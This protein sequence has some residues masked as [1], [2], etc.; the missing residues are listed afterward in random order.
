MQDTWFW[1]IAW[2]L[3]ILSMAGNGF[4]VF[5]VRRNRRLRTK[6]NAF[7][8][9]LAVADFCVP[10]SAVPSRFFCEMVDRCTGMT[11][12]RGLFGY[13]SATNLC[14]LVLDRYMAVAKPLKY[15]TFM[16]SRRVFQLISLSWAIPVAF[17]AAVS[18]LW[19]GLKTLRDIVVGWFYTVYELLLCSIVVF[20]F[21]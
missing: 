9:S 19:Y 5:T 6:T 3:Y 17:S 7:I 14:S 13:A 10:I 18:L 1:F 8:A 16:K 20:C 4:V 21:V 15:L 11:L 12:L 2:L